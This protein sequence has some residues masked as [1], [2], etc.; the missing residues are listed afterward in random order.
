FPRTSITPSM[1]QDSIDN[2]EGT[3]SPMLS[4]RDLSQAEVQKHVDATNHYLPAD[5]HIAISLIN[6]PRNMV[7]TGPPMSLYGL[8]S[9]LRKVKAPTGLD[10]NR[11]PYTERKV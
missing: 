2:G 7:V 10:Q 9:R 5:R 4:I 6:S 1:L 3:P 11:I 8:N